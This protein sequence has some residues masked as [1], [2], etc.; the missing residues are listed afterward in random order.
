MTRSRPPAHLRRAVLLLR[1]GAHLLRRTTLLLAAA[2]LPAAALS[3]CGESDGPQLGGFTLDGAAEQRTVETRLLG[4]FSADTMSAHHE[5]MTAEPHHAASEA[6]R[7][8]AEY[9]ADALRS[10]GFDDVR[11]I[12]YEALIPRPTTRQVTVLGPERRELPL[13]EPPFEEDPA[14]SAEDVVT[15]YNAYSGDGDVTA[16]VVY[17]NYGLP[18]DYEVLDSLGVSVEGKIA[19][20]RY[21]M[22]WRGIK[23][24]LAARHGAVGTI[25]YSDPEDDGYVEGDTLPVGK[26]R[27]ARGVQSGSVMD[28]PTYPGDPQT[29][30]RPSV[31]GAERIPRTEAETILDVPVLPISYGNARH[32]LRHL[33]GPEGPEEWQGGLDL[34][35]RV[36]PGATRVRL[37]VESDWSVRPFVNVVG[38]L[39]GSEEPEKMVMAGAHRDAWTFGGRDP[40]SGAVSLLEVGRR[41]G[42]LAREGL[43]PRRSVALASWGAEE[44]GLI[45][46]TEYGEHFADSLRG[47][48]V[49]YL[50]RESYTAGDFDAGG[51]H[52][53]EPFLNGIA[54]TV[55]MPDTAATIH[56]GWTG[57]ADSSRL[58]DPEGTGDP[59]Q[60]RLEALGSG[61]D[62]TV[63]LDH[64][65]IPAADVGFS[66]GNG[67][68]HSKYD[69]RWF[70]TE[71]GDPGFRYGETLSEV[72][73]LFLLR[74][75]NADV[76]PLD[77]ERTA[78][79]MA[80][81]REELGALAD[82]TGLAD[83]V[84]LERIDSS[85]EA[86]RAAAAAL[87]ESVG[88]ITSLRRDSLTSAGAD[89][90]RRLNGLLLQVEQD[91]LVEEGLPGRPWYRHQLYAP[92][93]Y[94]G[95]GV[96]TLP[97]V[98]EALEQGDV[99]Q[100]RR[101]TDR[102]VRAVDR[103]RNTLVEAARVARTVPSVAGP[104]DGS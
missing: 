15:P 92:G 68:Y 50:N 86:F 74:L 35:Y 70:F 34:P 17:V 69:S 57:T 44:Y 16:E 26:W 98:R 21:G 25:L 10:Y 89:S 65:G 32:I 38:I 63:F 11:L 104:P 14:S 83:S 1:R 93:F 101:M 78:E 71:F 40:I 28:M 84:D 51:V 96:K 80:R 4:S 36:G 37:R 41:L 73:A 33:E 62:Y 30:G 87:N 18:R 53:L 2:A 20:A 91:F 46:S 13:E 82:S 55:Q 31:P 42:E 39:R 48:L 85:V 95:Y 23:P 72:A 22:S 94:T 43:R 8:Y 9:Y 49:A 3:A 99:E 100:A 6:N 7:R 54:R 76:L 64:L 90:L 29:P 67:I 58:R 47:R 12:E 19:L 75:A 24:R 102:L 88:E 59:R 77:Y 97:G 27:P 5:H 103:A 52:S 66:S 45:G 56:E 79:T 60:V 61:S 81:Y